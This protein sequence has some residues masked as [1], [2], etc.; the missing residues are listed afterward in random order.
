M[1]MDI[2]PQEPS[3]AEILFDVNLNGIEQPAQPTPQPQPKPH[4][5]PVV[6]KVDP[7]A[8]MAALKQIVAQGERDAERREATR[9][10]GLESALAGQ[11]QNPAPPVAGDELANALDATAI[12][13]EEKALPDPVTIAEIPEPPPESENPRAL[14]NNG[15]GRRGHFALL[16]SVSGAGKSVLTYQT[17]Y[18]WTLGRAGILGIEPVRPLKIGYIGCE[19]DAEELA[20]FR[21]SMRKGYT[22]QGWTP[23]EI[24][25][26]E[27]CVFDES[28]AFQGKTGG[29]FAIRLATVLAVR[30]YDLIVLNPLQGY[31]G[32]D[33]SSNAELSCFLRQHLDPV[34]KRH[35]TMMLAVHHTN[36]PPNAKD[37]QGWG[38]D[39]MSAYI[40]A[41]GAEL[42]NFTR[43]VM[44]L[45]PCE[46]RGEEKPGLYWIVGA[47]RGDRLGWR[48]AD[49][50][51]VKKRLI[52]HS[53][54]G[55]LF[56]REAT[57]EEK[58]EAGTAEKRKPEAVAQEIAAALKEH[59]MCRKDFEEA[60][61]VPNIKSAKGREA[62]GLVTKDPSRFGLFAAP[63][64]G[65]RIVYYGTE[66]AARA[67]ASK[68]ERIK[69]NTLA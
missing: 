15:W 2:I 66:E 55:L 51:P 29:N 56:W 9:G 17:I 14:F 8:A 54:N 30:H 60:D 26:A 18:A 27:S 32:F 19:D 38:A 11:G 39:A 4:E 10:Q 12:E 49:G 57:D 69:Q 47:K 7:K 3:D 34:L 36:K 13:Q 21:R 62:W 46:I 37:R 22:A 44:S 48:D 20:E 1:D 45:M 52:A 61:G 35:G 31:T 33:L 67:A 50:Q 6:K 28:A 40:G 16:V 58:A 25:N 64:L 65:A 24:A 43:A 68:Q 63:V 42:V 23:A 59:A 41:G 5:T 53:G